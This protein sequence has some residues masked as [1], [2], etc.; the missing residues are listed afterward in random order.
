MTAPE[1]MQPS[2]LIVCGCDEVFILDGAKLAKGEV[3]RTWRWTV[4]TCPNLPADLR[5]AFR[6]TDECKPVDGGRRILVTSSSGGIA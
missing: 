5:P 2:D 4:A 6:T 3:V 1:L